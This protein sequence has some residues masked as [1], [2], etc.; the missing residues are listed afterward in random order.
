VNQAIAIAFLICWA[1]ATWWLY[2]IHESWVQAAILG[3]GVVAAGFA[4]G[5]TL[6]L[7]AGVAL[8]VIS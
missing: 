8:G 1:A 3:I 4:V 7:L 5:G 6:V 2:R